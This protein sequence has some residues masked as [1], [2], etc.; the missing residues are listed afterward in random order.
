MEV[1]R[2]FGVFSGGKQGVYT[3]KNLSIHIKMECNRIDTCRG[4]PRVKLKL[5]QK[6]TQE[7]LEVLKASGCYRKACGGGGCWY[8]SDPIGAITR[9]QQL[10]EVDLAAAVQGAVRAPASGF[11]VQKVY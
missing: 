4:E 2:H 3:H 8:L 11:S 1:A 6:P 7:I 9:L 5:P 10:G